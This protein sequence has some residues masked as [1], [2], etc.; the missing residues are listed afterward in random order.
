MERVSQCSHCF[1]CGGD[2]SGYG[3]LSENAAFARMCEKCGIDFI[4]PSPESMEAM[5]DKAS[6]RKIMDEA[7]IPVIPGMEGTVQEA[8]EAMKLADR[9]GYPIMIKASAGGGGKGM[10]VVE[11]RGGVSGAVR[12]G[13]AGDREGGLLGTGEN[14]SG[15]VC[16]PC[17][18][19]GSAG[20]GGSLRKQPSI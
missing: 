5:G 14:V 1:R 20:S 12:R 8:E 6:A 10:R 18:T 15:A 4:G 16:A 9:I 2:S 3:F 7:G 13:S 11:R 17:Q 19:C